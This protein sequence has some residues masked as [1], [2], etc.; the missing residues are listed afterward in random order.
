MM[1]RRAE[2]PRHSLGVPHESRITNRKSP[3]VYGGPMSRGLL[4]RRVLFVALILGFLAGRG[5]I[6]WAQT[7]NGVIS[8]IVSDAQGGVL[9]GVTLTLRNAET[10]FTRTAVTQTD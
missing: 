7:T 2:S 10:G 6:A 9:P 1:R 3:V 4:R 8:G 5:S